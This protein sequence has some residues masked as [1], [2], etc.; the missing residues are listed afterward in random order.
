[1]CGRLEEED[2]WV[3]TLRQRV[4]L[5]SSSS[6]SHCS[7]LLPDETTLLGKSIQ[8]I[9][10]GIGLTLIPDSFVRISGLRV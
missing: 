1:M 6:V 7:S 4:V 8:W 3:V 9:L 10:L 5:W 2:V